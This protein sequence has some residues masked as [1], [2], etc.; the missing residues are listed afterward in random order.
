MPATYTLIASNTLSSSAAS[1]TFSSISASYTDLVVSCSL[2]GTNASQDET[3]IIRF[4]G[5]SSAYSKTDL[6]ATGT[7]AASGRQTSASSIQIGSINAGSSTANTFTPVEIYIPSYTVS[8]NKP[9]SAQAFFEN[10]STTA[11]QWY[12]FTDAGLWSNTSAITSIAFSQASG[13]DFASG[14][15]FFLYGIKN[16]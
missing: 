8:Q 12:I 13:R 10:N 15:S 9:L 11:G 4:N 16:S 1:V 6:Q 2:R 7:T 5:V 3:L 14:S